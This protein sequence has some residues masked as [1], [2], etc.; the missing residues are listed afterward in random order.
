MTHYTTL[1]NKIVSVY[2]QNTT[3]N[4]LGEDVETM[5]LSD[6][7]VIC[8]LVPVSAEQKNMLP[9]EFEDVKYNGYFLSSQSLS[10]NDQI[11]YDGKMYKIRE[12]YIDS[13]GHTRKALLSEL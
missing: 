2:T 11:G 8:R 3:P 13:S 10:T 9:G 1:L 7:N 4:S 5:T 12:V 6:S